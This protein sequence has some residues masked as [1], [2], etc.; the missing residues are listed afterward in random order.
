MQHVRHEYADLFEGP[1]GT[2][3]ILLMW[4]DNLT[5]VARFIDAC[6]HSGMYKCQLAP[7]LGARHLLSPD[8][9]GRDGED[10]SIAIASGV[11]AAV[12][13]AASGHLNMVRWRLGV[14][15]TSAADLCA[16]VL[17]TASA[18]HGCAC[19]YFQDS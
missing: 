16:G 4:Q 10:P 8:L 7:Q 15:L 9:A 13:L 19:V 18:G 2:A 5:G 17:T 1:Q 14:F 11:L 3:M 6:L 12:M